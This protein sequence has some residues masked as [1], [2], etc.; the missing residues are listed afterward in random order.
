MSLITKI[1]D[2]HHKG[3]TGAIINRMQLM[4]GA[5][6]GV[7]TKLRNITSLSGDCRNPYY[8]AIVG[9]EKHL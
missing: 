7:Y 8:V 2:L 1:G 9:V 4:C 3:C 6:F 5:L